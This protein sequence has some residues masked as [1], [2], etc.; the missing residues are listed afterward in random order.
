MDDKLY[1]NCMP[2]NELAKEIHQDNIDRGF[3]E[4]PR[5]VGTELMLIVSELSEALEAFRKDKFVNREDLN[6][7][8]FN[9]D[10]FR[11]KIKDTFEDEIA[12]ALIRILDMCGNMNIDITEHVFQKLKYNRTREYKHGGKKI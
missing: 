4:K 12:D 8:L 11:E 9:K 3:Y 7:H 5:E 1:S 2:L 6:N 10:H